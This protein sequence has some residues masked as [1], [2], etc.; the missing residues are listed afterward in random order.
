ME[1]DAMKFLTQLNSGCLEICK[2]MLKSAQTVGLNT[3]DFIIACLDKDSYEGLKEYPGAFLYGDYENNNLTGYQDWSFDPNSNFRKIVKSK[4]KLISEIH[5]KHKFLCWVDTD[6]VFVQNPMIF[7][8]D[9]IKTLF[10][11]DIPGSLICSGFMVFN[12]TPTSEAIVRVC[13][14]NTE[15]DDQI[16]INNLVQSTPQYA[17]ECA[18]LSQ[19]IFPN[20][21]VYHTL[22]EKLNAVIV[23]NNHMVGIDTKINKFKEENLWF[24]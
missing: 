11:C 4:W 19:K 20:G 9:N 5:S 12:D 8:K 3:D 1:T 16:L 13:G 17:K 6:I 15:E 2:N 10:Q 23:H 14:S 24:I 18:L 21:Y 22:G 7:I